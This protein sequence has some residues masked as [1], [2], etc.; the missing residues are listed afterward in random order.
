MTTATKKTVIKAENQKVVIGSIELDVRPVGAPH[1]EYVPHSDP[2]VDVHGN[3]ETIAYAIQ[4]KLPVLL[5]GETGTGKTSAIRHLASVTNRPFRRINLNGSTTVDELVGKILINRDGTYWTDGVLTEALRNGYWLLLDEINAALPEVLF[6]LHSLL[7][8]DGYVVLSESETKEIV[9]PHPDFRIFATCNPFER[10]SGTKELN[11]AFL[12]RFPVVV[13]VKYPSEADELAVIRTK[14]ENHGVSDEVIASM[15]K[16]ANQVRT[17]TEKDEMDFTFSTR[18]LIHWASAYAYAKD[19]MKSAQMT[20]LGKCNAEDRKGIEQLIAINFRQAG[21]RGIDSVMKGDLLTVTKDWFVTNS[22]YVI[23]VGSKVEVVLV[24]DALSSPTRI[25]MF[26]I[27][28]L[29]IPAGPATM[30]G[31]NYKIPEAGNMYAIAQSDVVNK[32]V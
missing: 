32:Y 21:K 11:K 17:S 18:D 19:A 29:S 31:S 16:L 12:S 30:Q 20:F 23:P 25:P 4:N 1:S 3:L 27:K 28:I 26:R 15:V 6:T 7:D 9:R 10:Y 14:P 13:E 24:Q 8:D 2:F 5:I 22:T